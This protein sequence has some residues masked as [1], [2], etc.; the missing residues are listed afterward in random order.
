MGIH[1]APV[2]TNV[3][4]AEGNTRTDGSVP[5]DAVLPRRQLQGRGRTQRRHA[6]DSTAWLDVS[7]EPSVPEPPR[8]EGDR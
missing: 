6:L 5:A 7:K 8:G 3:G 2:M 1:T 4:G